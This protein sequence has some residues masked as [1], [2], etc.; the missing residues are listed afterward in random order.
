MGG[1]VAWDFNLG[2]YAVETLVSEAFMKC[3][4]LP[5]F[6]PFYAVYRILQFL[7]GLFT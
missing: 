1:R 5:A 6:F 7:I 3:G 2:I 4:L